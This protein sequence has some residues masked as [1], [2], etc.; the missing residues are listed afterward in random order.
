MASTKNRRLSLRTFWQQVRPSSLKGWSLRFCCACIL[1]ILESVTSVATPWLFSG[2]VGR[3]SGHEATLA[4]IMALLASYTV[5]RMLGAVAGPVRSLLMVPIRTVL[6]ERISLRG[7][8]HIH[9]LSAR[10]HQKRQTG[11]LT[12]TIDRGAD[13]ASTIV[14]M[15]FSNV[16]PN[17][18]GLGLTFLV[19]LHVF[20]GWYLV[21]LCGTLLLYAGISFLFTR[22]RM[23]ARRERNQANSHAH[24]HL[25]DS[26]LN[27][28]IVRAFG[29]ATYESQ[30]QEKIWKSLN[31]AEARLQRL[32]GSSQA[33]RNILIS[34]AT[35]S[36]LGMA[37]LDIEAHRLGV[38]QFVLM[39][40]YLR[41]VYASVGALNYVGAGWRNA[42][43]DMEAYL[44]LMALEPEIQSPQEPVPLPIGH[45][46]GVT[47]EMRHVAFGYEPERLILRDVSFRLEA[48]R[49]LA[50]VGRSGSGKSTLAKLISRLYDPLEGVVLMEDVP[51]TDLSLEVLRAQI[52]VVAQ[53]TSL[54]N[55]TIA[56]NIAYG[57]VGAGIADIR[58]AAEAAQLGPLIERLPD[59][60]DTLVGERGVRLSGGERQRMAI[61]RVLLRSPR[62]L[63]LDEATSALDTRTEDAIQKELMML[64]SGRTTVVIAHRLST[65]QRADHILVM[66]AGQVVEEGTHHDLLEKGGI[67]A[68]MWRLQARGGSVTGHS[69]V[70]G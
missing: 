37:I 30:R 18:L 25:V 52:G 56:E 15:A 33:V 38:A 19:V 49:M 60:F 58:R 20:N 3:L 10:F 70:E 45:P 4:A 35:A 6:R 27:A 55:A 66:E 16:M 39:G 63:V 46:R 57:R 31:A 14:D 59:G 44:E 42:R 67:Y 43:V 62:L 24:R 61:A 32:I 1:L 34:L 7:L 2:M 11:A 22:W 51:L 64:S 50:V 53:D 48:G 69:V 29:N 8:E 9:Q 36:L 12:R 54:F 21:L 41:S 23:Q 47:L 13:A 26:L 40:T 68:G 5:L 28:D 65:I 17:L